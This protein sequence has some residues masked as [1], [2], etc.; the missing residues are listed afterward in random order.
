MKINAFLHVAAL[1]LL[2]L[3]CDRNSRNATVTVDTVDTDF[4]EGL[5]PS[6]VILTYKGV[7]PCVDC[8]GINTQLEINQ[9]SS[10]FTLAETFQGKASGDSS[11]MF[12]GRFNRLS[13]ADSVSTVLELTS[14]D[15]K[16]FFLVEG[17]TS[18]LKLDQ[19]AKTINSGANY[20]LMR[21]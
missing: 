15:R 16:D 10:T 3:S 19:D 9:D 5:T 17:D 8:Q 1:S 7:L 18:L 14:S 20:R 2:L 11:F 12:S 4:F 6:A 13:A 21:L